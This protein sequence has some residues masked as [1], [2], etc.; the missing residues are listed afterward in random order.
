MT[1]QPPPTTSFLEIATDW[2]LKIAYSLGRQGPKT[3]SAHESLSS[4][5]MLQNTTFTVVD[6]SDHQ[7][8][9]RS[10]LKYKWNT[11]GLDPSILLPFGLLDAQDPVDLYEFDVMTRVVTPAVRAMG[12]LFTAAFGAEVGRGLMVKQERKT[13]GRTFPDVSVYEGH[14]KEDG[15]WATEERPL[16]NWEGKGPL[17]AVDEALNEGLE[18]MTGQTL[19][20]VAAEDDHNRSAMKILGQVSL[21][22]LF[23]SQQTT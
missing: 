14:E 7:E 19:D 8:A 16:M 9:P 3:P 20:K 13:T 17:A 6:W 21:L 4:R 5:K 12:R 11:A 15:S 2:S 18:S 1:A 22:F 10:L 23:F